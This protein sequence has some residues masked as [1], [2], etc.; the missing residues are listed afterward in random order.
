ME[1]RK[2][3][4][5]VNIKRESLGIILE[6][7]K[8][9]IHVTYCL[10]F[11]LLR[12][13]LNNKDQCNDLSYILHVGKDS[14]ILLK[15][16]RKQHCLKDSLIHIIMITRTV[17]WGFFPGSCLETQNELPQ[18]RRFKEKR[19][20]LVTSRFRHLNRE[21]AQIMCCLLKPCKSR[22]KYLLQAC[23]VTTR[24]ITWWLFLP[25]N[26]SE[27]FLFSVFFLCPY[28]ECFL[29]LCISTPCCC[30]SSLVFPCLLLWVHRH[31][32]IPAFLVSWLGLL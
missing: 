9:K 28:A 13:F 18:T 24:V 14:D 20:K 25:S 21:G 23:S 15:L 5:G 6:A 12:F 17:S 11:L 29:F 4:K 10:T 2:T 7:S 1:V 32:V 16:E 3:H 19:G 26:G 22:G 27:L 8:N 30:R 31:F